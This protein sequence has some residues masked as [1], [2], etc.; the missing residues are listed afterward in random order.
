MIEWS[1]PTLH[2]N[3]PCASRGELLLRSV[4]CGR[5]RGVGCGVGATSFDGNC[6]RCNGVQ[7]GGRNCQWTLCDDNCNL[8]LVVRFV[9]ELGWQKGL[10][11]SNR[12]VANVL[13][14]WNAI[15]QKMGSSLA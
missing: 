3:D 9:T 10:I 6:Q 1:L 11:E 14:H 12:S 5:G 15:L 13:E 2:Q 4:G 8:C 7:R